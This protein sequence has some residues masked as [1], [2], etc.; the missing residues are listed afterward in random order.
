MGKNKSALFSSNSDEWA[1]PQDLFDELNKEF[2]FTLD[3]C[4]T[5]E[6]HKLPF[7]FTK[8]NDGLSQD[9]GGV[10]SVL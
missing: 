1:T 9:W 6:N 3:A 5:E 8:E 2:G 7:Y 4:A 10:E